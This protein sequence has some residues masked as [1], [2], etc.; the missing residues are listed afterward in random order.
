MDII[1][2][3]QN[4]GHVLIPSLLNGVPQK[5]YFGTHFDITEKG[6][7]QLDLNL[8]IDHFDIKAETNPY[9]QI[10]LLHHV[11]NV[12]DT[13]VAPTVSEM[14]TETTTVAESGTQTIREETDDE[15]LEASEIS[16]TDL[17]MNTNSDTFWHHEDNIVESHLIFDSNNYGLYFDTIADK[18]QWIHVRYEITAEPIYVI[19]IP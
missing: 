14:T 19:R 4:T 8:K 12:S 1:E 18:S 3:D 15:L 2:I 10:V 5:G 16:D 11:S 9:L 6:T 7:F 13:T 17:R